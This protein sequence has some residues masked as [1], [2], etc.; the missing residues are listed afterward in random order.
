LIAP[1]QST[2]YRSNIHSASALRIRVSILALLAERYH[3]LPSERRGAWYLASDFSRPIR[4]LFRRRRVRSVG[5][6]TRQC[7]H[8]MGLEKQCFWKVK[9]HLIAIF[10][11][12]KHPKDI[13]RRVGHFDNFAHPIAPRPLHRLTNLPSLLRQ[14]Q[15]WMP[16]TLP[17]DARARP[18]LR[19]SCGMTRLE[20]MFSTHLV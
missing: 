19:M 20:S 4:L 13:L 16:I 7:L 5:D 3:E 9:S 18:M 10:G 12:L 2:Q 17:K 6:W 14:F 8:P 15:S 11:I 1:L